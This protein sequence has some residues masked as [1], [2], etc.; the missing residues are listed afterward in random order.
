M[1][2]Y[3]ALREKAAWFDLSN[4]GKIR[5]LGEDHARLLHAMSTNDV[6]NL[7]DSAGLYTFFLND[8]GRI[9]CDA[10]VYR[11]PD[12]ILLDTEPETA[13]LLREHLDA[14]IIAD[15]V[16][17]EDETAH[18]AAIA[19]EGPQS[20]ENLAALGVPIPVAEWATAL[21]QTGWVARVSFTGAQAL[22]VF[23]PI[24]DMVSFT[25]K[26]ELAGI[27]NARPE[28]VKVVRLEHGKPRF[29]DDISS[30]YLAPETQVDHAVHSNKGC[31]LGQEIVERVRA[32]GQVHRLLSAIRVAG[33]QAPEPGAK[34]QMEGKPVGEIT[35]AAYSD[36]L[37]EVVALA[38]VRR[39]AL[40]TK[41]EMVVAD[42]LPAL[43]ARLA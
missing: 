33:N 24:G 3:E 8:K 19:V 39:E 10:C 21:W 13:V 32:Q 26:L 6:K 15:D 17:L 36:A 38:Y 18:F 4:R 28:E 23:L 41:A 11:F 43:T 35:S 30:R 1:T 9:L 42:S 25:S 27:P 12:S 2:G 5:A 20:F 14:Y 40:H 37:G 22:R 16:T 7:A 31:Y 29:G 34:L